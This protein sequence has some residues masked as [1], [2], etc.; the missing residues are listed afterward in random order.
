[1]TADTTGGSQIPAAGTTDPAALLDRWHA[2]TDAATPG[3]WEAHSHQRQ[4]SIWHDELDQ[5]LAREVRVWLDAV[6]MSA[7]R[8]TMPRLVAALEAALALHRR[9]DEPERTHHVCP[10]HVRQR[11]DSR[12]VEAWREAVST[13]P[14]CTVTERYVCAHDR[15][16]AECPDD[17]AWPCPTWRAITAALTG[18]QPGE[19][20]G[21]G[22]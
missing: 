22:H 17:D 9:S 19:G 15:C 1:M 3:P 16:R 13:C 8:T 18:P 6:F 5:P 10:E 11:R 12:E 7:A 20:T 14:D 2:I 4:Y 21:N